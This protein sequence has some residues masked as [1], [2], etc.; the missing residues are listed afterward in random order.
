MKKHTFLLIALFTLCYKGLFA[1]KTMSDLSEPNVYTYKNFDD[2]FSNS[3]KKYVGKYIDHN[4]IEKIKCLDTV[5][6]TKI[7]IDFSDSTNVVGI[8]FKFKNQK[9]I[10]ENNHR[11]FYQYICGNKKLLVI[12]TCCIMYGTFDSNGELMSASF[13]TDESSYFYFVKDLDFN[14]KKKAFE[15]IIK[16]NPKLYEQFLAEKKEDKKLFARNHIE[17]Y[18]KYIKLYCD[19]KK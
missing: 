15:D 7:K 10:R 2:F 17:V 19:E 9:Y 12:Y 4:S 3:N 1:Q 5:T 18:K 14:N 13:M 11:S 16:D 8:T 6:K